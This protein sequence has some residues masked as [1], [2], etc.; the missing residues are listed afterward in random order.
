MTDEGKTEVVI[1]TGLSGAGK[2]QAADWFEDHGYY[3][4][5]NM[6]PSMI[7]EY[8]CAYLAPYFEWLAPAALMLAA[9]YTMWSFCRH[10]ELIA[11]RANG[12]GFFT[13]VKPILFVAALMAVAVWWVNDCYVPRRAQWAAS[14]KAE[15]F[16]LADME[17]EDNVVFR[18]AKADRTWT[19]GS[20]ADADARRLENVRV[21][22]DRPDGS[23]LNRPLALPT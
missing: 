17:R 23:R 12:L 5:D 13:I 7:A 10:S 19:V 16:R 1:V 6:P 21:T 22:V 8:F 11:M 2:T 20:L 18:N 3:V 15:R 4:I 14:L 9:L